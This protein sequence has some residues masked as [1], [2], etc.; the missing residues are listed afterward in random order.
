MSGDNVWIG[1]TMGGGTDYWRI[2]GYGTGD[3]GICR[4]IIGDNSNDKFQIQ[5]A[6]YSGT[7][8]TPLEVTYNK[9]NIVGLT[10][11]TANG[12]T[13]TIGS[14]NADHCHYSTDAPCH[15]FNKL[16]RV[17]GDVYG[18]S[19]Y[20]RRL[21]YVDEVALSGHTHDYAA[22]SHSHTSYFF[23][24]GNRNSSWDTCIDN[25]AF[26]TSNVTPVSGAYGYGTFLAFRS[27][28]TCVQ[29]YFPDWS[30]MPYF[31]CGWNAQSS[32][33]SYGW[34]GLITTSN[35]GS[36]SVNYANSAGNSNTVDGYHISVGSSAG[37]DAN[38]IYYIV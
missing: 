1:S 33:S 9:V 10:G 6:D 2:G 34:V 37:S 5:I 31:R 17:A 11:I 29:L 20:N 30:A 36:Q 21:A 18:G 3:N 27:Y 35:I 32:M 7:T 26:F 22:S 16:V 13:L 28:P 25:G 38:T 4:I 19:S 23:D 8:Y 14:Q 12:R 15:W 24:K